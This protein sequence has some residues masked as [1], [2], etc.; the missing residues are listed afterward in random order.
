[1]S[2]SVAAIITLTIPLALFVSCS[3]SQTPTNAV[4][5]ARKSSSTIAP[6][7][8]AAVAEL[9]TQLSEVHIQI[10][11]NQ[12]AL[13][14]NT[15]QIAASINAIDS[16]SSIAALRASGSNLAYSTDELQKREDAL[17]FKKIELLGSGKRTPVT[18]TNQSQTS[19]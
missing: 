1:M 13:E 9:E 14:E 7:T 17:T 12:A 11:N 4:A 6:E 5:P 18:K 15:K 3:E 8:Q 2:K 16:A 10:T 19:N